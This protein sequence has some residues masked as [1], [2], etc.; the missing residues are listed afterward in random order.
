MASS[1]WRPAWEREGHEPS[2]AMGVEA[3]NA[4]NPFGGCKFL[5]GNTPAIDVLQIDRNEGR[6]YCRDIALLF[7]GKCIEVH[8]GN[9]ST[10]FLIV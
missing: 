3:G 5:W 7:A 6:T 9:V 1:T 2:W 8:W 10:R 4:H